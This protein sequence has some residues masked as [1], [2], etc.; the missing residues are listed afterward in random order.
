MNHEPCN[1]LYVET[2]KPSMQIQ[3][4]LISLSKLELPKLK[5]LDQ[6]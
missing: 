2:Q 5:S 4:L 3:F 6:T 1:T